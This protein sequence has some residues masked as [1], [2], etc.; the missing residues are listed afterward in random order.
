MFRV[1]ALLCNPREPRFGLRS[2]PRLGE[3]QR[4]VWTISASRYTAKT[5]ARLRND[6]EHVYLRATICL[7]RCDLTTR[8]R[9]VID[10]AQV[11]H[12]NDSLHA[13]VSRAVANP[14]ILLELDNLPTLECQSGVCI[15]LLAPLDSSFT[16]I[17]HVY[18]GKVE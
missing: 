18:V 5:P 16:C 9:R 4:Y 14:A 13:G 11:S 7:N 1:C 2:R 15:A 17:T 3:Q 8:T 12:R 10:N 6:P